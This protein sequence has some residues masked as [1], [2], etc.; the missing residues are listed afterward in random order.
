MQ[1]TVIYALI[2]LL[3][4]IGIPV[5]A[6]LNSG[7]G[8]RLANPALAATILFLVGL[9]VAVIN[10]ML[11]KGFSF[12]RI[13]FFIPWYYYLGGFLVMF[14][15]LSITAITPHFGVSNA[16]AFVLLG[17]IIAMTVIDHFGLFGVVPFS[18]NS[19]RVIGVLFMIVGVF[20]VLSK[21]T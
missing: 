7:L 17:Q 10:L 14:Y 13:D 12:N 19:Q 15:I 20:L 21:N 1:N 8:S 3:A 6:A 18:I 9:S 2:M 4:G 5:M 16:I 11:T